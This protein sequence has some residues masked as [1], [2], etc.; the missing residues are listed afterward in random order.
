MFLSQPFQPSIAIT[1]TDLQILIT[2]MWSDVI[3]MF[4][5][6]NSI[7]VFFVTF[8]SDINY[9]PGKGSLLKTNNNKLK[10]TNLCIKSF[11]CCNMLASATLKLSPWM[12][13]FSLWLLPVP[14][15]SSP[16]LLWSPPQTSHLLLPAE[17]RTARLKVQLHSRYRNQLTPFPCIAISHVSVTSV[18]PRDPTSLFLQYTEVA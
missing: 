2:V 13:L 11:E 8:L 6:H 17:S 15:S 1:L 7:N 16:V 12:L 18:T 4:Q 9:K 3:F 10:W 14:F 5:F